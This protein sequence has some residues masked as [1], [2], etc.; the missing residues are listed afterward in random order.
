MQELGTNDAAHI[1]GSHAEASVVD[2]QDAGDESNDDAD[3][4]ENKEGGLEP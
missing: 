3:P 4:Q 1:D 2:V